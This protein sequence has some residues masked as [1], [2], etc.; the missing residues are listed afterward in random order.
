MNLDNF[1]NPKSVAVIGASS[2]KNKVGFAL[3]SNLVKSQAKRTIFPISISESEILG[4]KTFKSVSEI[5]EPI[6]LAIIAVRA[7]IVPSILA[8]CGTK[9]IKTVIII[10]AGFR[11]IGEAGKILEEKVAEVAKENDIALL[12]PNC[13]GAIDLQKDFNGSFSALNPK[14]GNIAFLSQSGALGTSVL[15]LAIAEGVGFSKFISLGNEAQLTEIEFLEYL[16]NDP[17]TKAILIYLEKLSNGKKFMELASEITKTK[18]IVVLKAG[19][20]ARGIK[21]VMSH[22]G[23]LAPETA[24]FS[25]ALRQSGAIAVESIR[26]FF[27]MA[28]LFELGIMKPIQNLAILTNGGG[29]S[30]VATDLIDLSKSLS[31]AEFSEK[32]K[33]ELRKVLPPMA[34]VGNPVDIIGDALANRYNDALKIISE[35]KDIDGI[36]LILTPQMMT[37]VLGTAKLIAEYRNKKPIIPVLLGGPTIEK[38]LEFFKQNDMVNF[39]FP[40]DAVEALDNLSFGKSKNNAS[41]PAEARPLQD[42]KMIDFAEMSKILNEFGIQICGTLAK[43]KSELKNAFEKIGGNSFAIKA[44]SSEIVHKTDSGAVKL[45]I[46]NAEE[47]ESAWNEIGAKSGN[48]PL[49]GMLVQPMIKGKEIIIGMKRDST[50]GPTILFGLGGIFTEIL[51][52]SSLRVAPIDFDSA[53]EMILE[54]K[55]AKILLGARGEKSVNIDA[56]ANLIV[57]ISKLSIAHPEI[58]EIDLNPVM[59]TTD[60]AIV[61]DA[62]IMV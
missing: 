27:N 14:K 62:R 35:Q 33:E 46:K 36:I 3:M 17:D 40:K 12:G 38:G 21:A 16:A 37:D 31:L 58:K 47:A 51:K 22:T 13:L 19:R 18:P 61:V 15:D 4:L 28:K 25:S 57:K 1:F 2:D 5:S 56:L 29:P 49:Q 60:S 20:S 43:N 7:D 53:K 32:T 42:L 6:D 44:I 41:E 10:S 52:D 8:E 34:A 30:V 50:F 59:A 39:K 48:V 23:S 11:E 45:N 55:S 54:I 26:E 9:K 24:V